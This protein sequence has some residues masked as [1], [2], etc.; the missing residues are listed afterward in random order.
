[1]DITT[2]IGTNDRPITEFGSETTL[3]YPAVDPQEL[4]RRVHL[5]S[6]ISAHDRSN[7]EPCPEDFN[8][9]IDSGIIIEESG[10]LIDH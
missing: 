6:G 7:D 9:A 10:E 5:T 1:M 3:S 2:E 8:E 4:R